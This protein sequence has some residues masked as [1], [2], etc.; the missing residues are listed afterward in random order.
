MVLIT[1][2]L[3]NSNSAAS[4]LSFSI[5]SYFPVEFLH[6]IALW[7]LTS[8]NVTAELRRDTQDRTLMPS[9]LAAQP[10]LSLA[11][12]T[13]GANVSLSLGEGL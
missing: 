10:E 11:G 6:P 4:F 3:V 13:W 2:P 7:S 1:P 12:S 8:Y 5:F 9:S